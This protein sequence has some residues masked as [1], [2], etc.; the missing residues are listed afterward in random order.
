MS[1]NT[2][3]IFAYSNNKFVEVDAIYFSNDSNNFTFTHKDQIFKIDYM[4]NKKRK[5]EE[6]D[7][8]TK[9][10]QE[11]KKVLKENIQLNNQ[12]TK[13]IKISNDIVQKSKRIIKERDE[14]MKNLHKTK[15]E[16]LRARVQ[17]EKCVNKKQ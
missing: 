13:V 7:E 4:V 10:E 2:L 5:R 12:L 17:L 8:E 6:F 11:H 3:K 14:C 15:M 16:L 1:D 9:L